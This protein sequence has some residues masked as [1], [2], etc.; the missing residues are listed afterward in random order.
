M[1]LDYCDSGPAPAGLIASIGRA[2][3]VVIVRAGTVDGVT[4]AACSAATMLAVLEPQP[5][6]SLQ[7]HLDCTLLHQPLPT[8][9][10][11]PRQPALPQPQPGLASSPYSMAC[12]LSRCACTCSSAASKASDFSCYRLRACVTAF[13]AMLSTFALQ[14]S[15]V[16]HDEFLQILNRLA[17]VL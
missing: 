7:H 5:L 15:C 12:T 14:N 3:T 11:E 1:L 9:H 4:D 2:S 16:V 13:T 6:L 17:N 8:R 10:P